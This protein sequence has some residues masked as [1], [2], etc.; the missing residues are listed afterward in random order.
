MRTL[1]C[2]T[3]VM[4]LATVLAAKEQATI[5]TFTLKDGR[6]IDA[7]RFAAAGDDGSKIFMITTVDGERLKINEADI[8]SRT[9]KK[10]LLSELSEKAR[11]QI[12][13]VRAADTTARANARDEDVSRESSKK[14]I[15]VS[16]RNDLEARIVLRKADEVLSQA[17][18]HLAHVKQV[19]ADAAV[20]IASA[21]AEYDGAKTE[22]GSVNDSVRRRGDRDNRESDRE[23]EARR[24]QRRD[25]LR[26]KMRA[27][28]EEK[29]RQT[30]KK[31]EGERLV[32]ELSDKI[33]KLG[34]K[35]E[36]AQKQ[37]DYTSAEKS[38]AIV[39][40]NTPDKPAKKSDVPDEST[41]MRIIK[42]K[43]GTKIRAKNVKVL[44]GGI[45]QVTDENG[46]EHRVNP[47]DVETEL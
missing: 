45:F 37:V 39:A 1:L 9:E 30:Q 15:A 2:C 22:L 33:K 23:L 18:T 16:V 7:I 35:R 46:V 28:A 34:E 4:L 42:L 10:M 27:A 11:G 29:T 3:A 36:V 26:K 43:D 25:V 41:V 19:I 13:S 6:A 31:N 12:Q 40:A 8:V 5:S 14:D 47:K 21:D 17:N 38:K 44:D 20:A 24:E 32:S